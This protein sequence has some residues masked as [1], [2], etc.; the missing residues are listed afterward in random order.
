MNRRP[1]HGL[2][3]RGSTDC[4]RRAPSNAPS[5]DRAANARAARATKTR[6]RMA[7]AAAKTQT[8]TL[9]EAANALDAQKAE[10]ERRFKDGA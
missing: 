1:T 2:S 6:A 4:E 10:L 7:K 5:R 8:A 3:A 9:A